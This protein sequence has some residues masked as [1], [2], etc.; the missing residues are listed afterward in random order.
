M[1][2]CIPRKKAVSI[3]AI[4]DNKKNSEITSK[5]YGK[6]LNFQQGKYSPFNELTKYLSSPLH[7]IN[8]CSSSNTINNS[9]VN[10]RN[11]DND[12]NQKKWKKL[13][14]D[15]K[16]LSLLEVNNSQKYFIIKKKSLKN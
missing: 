2:C 1:G 10:T 5:K 9:P 8:I 6:S 11:N 12:K 4:K 16:D 15:L 3:N 14:K 13:M 7:N